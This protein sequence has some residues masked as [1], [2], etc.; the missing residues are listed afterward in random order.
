MN[1]IDWL[2]GESNAIMIRPRQLR[3]SR[4][5]LTVQEF[6]RRVRAVGSVAART[7]VIRSR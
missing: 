2:A 4:F 6:D 5:N 7:V 3:S 1:C